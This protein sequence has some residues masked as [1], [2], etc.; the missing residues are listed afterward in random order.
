MAYYT[1]RLRDVV[2]SET[3]YGSPMKPTTKER[4]EMGRQKI[5]DF[6]YPLFDESYRQEFETRFIRTFYMNEISEEVFGL[7]K[8]KLENWL[9]LHMS[10]YNQLYK[11][12]LIEY[13]PLINT[14][15]K[16]T[17]LAKKDI[18]QTDKGTKN[19]G[20][21]Q[22]STK[23]KVMTEDSTSHIDKDGD[24]HTTGSSNTDT[25]ADGTDDV[26]KNGTVSDVEEKIGSDKGNK[27]VK[28]FERKVG[29]N[30]PD[31]RLQITT[32]EDGTG[33][34]EYASQIDE[35][36]DKTREDHDKST[37]ENNKN[38]RT[39]SETDKS[40]SSETGNSKT[41]GKS[42]V[43]YHD[44]TKGTFNTNQN[45]DETGK[46]KGSLDENTNKD[47]KANEVKDYIEQRV[48]KQG[49]ETYPEM[50]MKFRSAMINV[51]EQILRAMR[52]ELFMIVY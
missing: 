26:T 49:V 31:S 52:K 34:I 30:T 39:S 33:V 13:D 4:I 35:T 42:D 51:D 27:D 5:F 47:M 38:D 25:K 19:Q 1:V 48:G 36:S 15:Y 28:E 43:D 29:S 21:V 7:W 40:I 11:S 32:N 50:V 44:T 23:G 16:V 9:N 24:S 3:H 22:D 2:E 41:D 14:D 8:F 46:I 17:S 12:T 10:Y 6:D 37:K 18:E 45:T 20:T